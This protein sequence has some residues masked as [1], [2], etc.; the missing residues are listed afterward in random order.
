MAEQGSIDRT[1][2]GPGGAQRVNNSTLQS[3]GGGFSDPLAEAKA[4]RRAM[5]SREF[6][7]YLA[8]SGMYELIVKLLVGI[9]ESPEHAGGERPINAEEMI[10]DIFGT[11]R[12]PRWDEV[13][14]LWDTIASEKTNKAR[15]MERIAELQEQLEIEGKKVA[16]LRLWRA[17]DGPSDGG[18]VAGKDLVQKI[19]GPLPKKPP[20]AFVEAGEP[21][22][23]ITFPFW[24]ERMMQ[25][26]EGVRS[27]ACGELLEK[28]KASE[29]EAPYAGDLMTDESLLAFLGAL[30]S[31]FLVSEAGE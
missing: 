24:T 3:E 31:Q 11:Y 4:K 6:R 25:L 17:L 13:E 29:G 21:P 18:E 10:T 1:Q 8:D 12:D 26:E 15:L 20:D 7:Q 30:S 19:V 9:M 23:A 5:K 22:A 2:P 27:W 16:A 28:L 14:S